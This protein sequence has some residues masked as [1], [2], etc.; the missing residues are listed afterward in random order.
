METFPKIG[1]TYEQVR[2]RLLK[3]DKYRKNKNLTM[4]IMQQ[5]QACEGDKAAHELA[6]EVYSKWG[7]RREGRSLSGAG[8][9]QCGIGDG[10]SCSDDESFTSLGCGRYRKTY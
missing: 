10:R 3:D 9:V 7:A 1:M 2:T 4:S 6:N 8:N 5:C